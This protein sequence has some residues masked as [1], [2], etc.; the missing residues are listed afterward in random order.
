MKAY[1]LRSALTLLLAL[2]SSALAQAAENDDDASTANDDASTAS[3]ESEHSAA[4]EKDDKKT[5]KHANEEAGKSAAPA[6]G[7]GHQF[8][9]RVGLVGGYRMVLRYD[10]SPLCHDF[11]PAKGKD[12]QKFCG[13]GAPFALDFAL[14]GALIDSFEPFLWARIGLGG[15]EKTNTEPLL[16]LGLG[17]RIYTMSDS[18]FK[19]FVEPAIG[20]ELEGKDDGSDTSRPSNYYRTDLLFHLAAGPH[21]DVHKN[22]GFYA[23]AGLTMGI[24]R[25]LHST[26]ELTAGIQGRI[27]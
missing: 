9:L 22:F 13:Y 12:Q 24:L 19:V 18:A 25:Y 3:D 11:D 5:A 14:G 15:E 16:V 17:T 7:H 6:Y 10:K 21:F 8:G 4:D 1:L 20:V 2:S 23:D 26:L 27:P